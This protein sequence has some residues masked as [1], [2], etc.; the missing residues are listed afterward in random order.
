VVYDYWV[1]K[2]DASGSFFEEA[3]TYN[4]LK[5]GRLEFGDDYEERHRFYKKRTFMARSHGYGFRVWLE[6]MRLRYFIEM[7]F[8]AVNVA[9]F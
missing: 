3:T 7:L 5:D 2:V 1:S 6:S 8:F 9:F 4:I